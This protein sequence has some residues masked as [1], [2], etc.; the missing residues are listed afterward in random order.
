MF[1]NKTMAKVDFISCLFLFRLIQFVYDRKAWNVNSIISADTEV[2][3][4][5]E[6]L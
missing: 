2:N 6:W 5:L 4:C 3:S 1:C